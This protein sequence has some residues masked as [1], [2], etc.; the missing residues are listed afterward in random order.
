MSAEYALPMTSDLWV[1]IMTDPRG[2]GAT[3][4]VYEQ[5]WLNIQTQH[6]P[7]LTQNATLGRQWLLQMNEGAEVTGKHIQMCM[8]LTRHILQSLE[9]SQ[10]SQARASHDYTA[11]PAIQWTVGLS[12][13]LASAVG[14]APSKDNAWSQTHQPLANNTYHDSRTEPRFRLQSAVMTLSRG[15]VAFS[16]QIGLSNKTVIMHTCR[17]DGMLLRPD[18]PATLINQ[19]INNRAFQNAPSKLPDGEVWSTTSSIQ[20]LRFAHLISTD[21]SD[22]I[23]VKPSDMELGD[24][25]GPLPAPTKGWVAFE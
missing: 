21:L 22:A 20:G 5:D 6:I 16:N 19:I 8:S 2:P 3:M 17:S 9:M 25:R 23:S 1:H 14:I 15:P 24:G 4:D 12:G 7:E 13:M 18:R 11:A 10:V